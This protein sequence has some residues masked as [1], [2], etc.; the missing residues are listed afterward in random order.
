MDVKDSIELRRLCEKVED[1]VRDDSADDWDCSFSEFSPI[2]KRGVQSILE[3]A[4]S[5]G[6]GSVSSSSEAAE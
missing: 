4:Y 2:A 5:L 6:V 3:E 1:E